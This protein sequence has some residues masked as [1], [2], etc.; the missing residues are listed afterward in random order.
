MVY[1]LTRINSQGIHY[2]LTGDRNKDETVI[3]RRG[4]RVTVPHNIEKLSQAWFHWMNG[5][6]VQD[7]FPF[8][9][10]D[11]REFLMTGITK[12]EWNKIMGDEK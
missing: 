2:V 3:F 9:T 12:E 5:K 1:S 7:A 11:E 4:K 8:L 6:F 10:A